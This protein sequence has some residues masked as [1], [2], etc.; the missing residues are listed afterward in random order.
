MRLGNIRHDEV[1]PSGFLVHLNVEN[2]PGGAWGTSRGDVTIV[3]LF[4]QCGTDDQVRELGVRVREFQEELGR[5]F[6]CVRA[7]GD[8]E[9]GDGGGDDGFARGDV[10]PDDLA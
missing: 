10:D 3:P 8:V 6:G 5:E 1:K 2:I 7:V 9:E 4:V